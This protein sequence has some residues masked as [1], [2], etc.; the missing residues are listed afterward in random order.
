LGGDDSSNLFISEADILGPR[1]KTK[2]SYEDRMASI[3]KGREDREKFG[4][5][6]GKKHQ[7]PDRKSST[8]NKEKKRSKPVMMILS[9]GAVKGKKKAS[10]RDKQKKLRAHIDKGKR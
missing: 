6:K 3:Q 7:D 5:R 9:S 10:L 1:K 2:A 4:S 8:T